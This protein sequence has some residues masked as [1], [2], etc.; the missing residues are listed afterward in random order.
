MSVCVRDENGY[1]RNR[2]REKGI[3]GFAC[4]FTHL[5]FCLFSL[6]F[7]SVFSCSNEREREWACYCDYGRIASGVDKKNAPG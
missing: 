7:L 1:K 6:P 2:K 3:Y 5:G 4:K